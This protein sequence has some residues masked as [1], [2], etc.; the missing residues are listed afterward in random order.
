MNTEYYLTVFQ[1]SQLL[2]VCTKTIRLWTNSGKL[3][4]IRTSNGHRR[5]SLREINKI[6][7]E[8]QMVELFV[9]PP[10]PEQLQVPF[11]PT[12][13]EPIKLSVDDLEIFQP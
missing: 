1:A 2:N 11:M 3:E 8:K 4:C 10:Q 12:K 9:E 5:I 6:R 13:K 7:R